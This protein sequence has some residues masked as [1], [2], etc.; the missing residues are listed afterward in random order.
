M[1]HR[2]STGRD[3]VSIGNAPTRGGVTRRQAFLRMGAL[4]LGAAALSGVSSAWGQAKAPMKLGFWMFENPQQRPWIHKRIK[5]FTEKNPN[6]TVDFQYF[7]FTDLGKKLSVGFATGTAPE[8]FVS[9]DWFMPTW[10]AK[11]LLAP[12]DVQRLGYAS[13]DAFKND[14]APAFINGAMKDGKLYGYPMWFYGYCNYVNTR[15]FKE[16][17][18]DPEKDWP[19][20]WEQLGEVAKRLTIKQG[21]KFTRQGFK[22][23]MHASMWTVIQFN[24]VLI[25]CGGQWFDKAGK[26]TV[27]NEAGVKAM[28]I[29][30]SIAKKYG[31]EDPADSIATNPLPMMDWLRERTPMFL[32]HPIP[33]V[34]I[35]SQNQ[36]MFEKAYYRPFPYPGVVA[37]KN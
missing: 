20:T 34:A 33:P 35:K 14:F 17:G 28:T 27:N 13:M 5:L 36:E 12:L 21:N 22:W 32:C 37:G 31:A 23:A 18:L 24:P 4:G 8:G 16:V 1:E 15:Q 19:K 6:I 11:D 26:C 7:P 9:Q 2:D 29:R 25:Q 10:F 30:A 3:E